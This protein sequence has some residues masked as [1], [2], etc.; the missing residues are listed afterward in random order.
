MKRRIL[1]TPSLIVSIFTLSLL[2]AYAQKATWQDDATW[3]VVGA[4]RACCLE[5]Y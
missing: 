4:L 3:F 2:L 1:L 5:L